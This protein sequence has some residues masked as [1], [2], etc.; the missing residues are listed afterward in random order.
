M[1]REEARTAVREER[2][3][4]FAAWISKACRSWRKHDMRSFW[5][6]IRNTAGYKLRREAA[7]GI[8]DPESNEVVT[9][10]TRTASIWANYFGGLA[11]DH[12]GHSKDP[13]YWSTRLVDRTETLDENSRPL[14]WSECAEVIKALA[15]GKASGLDGMPA[16]WFKVCLVGG[17]GAD[18]TPVSPMAKALWKL[19][20][21][22]WNS[23]TV[24]DSWNEASVVPVP[25]KGDLTRTDNYRGIALMQV[26]MKI[27][28]TVIA[29]RLQRLAE[30]HGLLTHA[31]AGFRS[32][33]EAVGQVAALYEIARRREIEGERTLVMFVDFAKAY[34][35]VPHAALLKKLSAMGIRGKLLRLLTAMYKAPRLS[36]KT[37]S[38]S[39]SESTPLEIGVRQGCPSSPILF[40]LF[41][42]DLVDEIE[43]GEMGVDIPAIGDPK[44]GALLFADDLVMMA[45]S[46]EQLGT[47]VGRL[48]RWCQR[49]EMKVNASKCGVMQIGVDSAADDLIVQ[50]GED[51]VPVVKAYTY[52][53]CHF[54][55][56]LDIEAMARHRAKIGSASLEELRPFIANGTIP[57]WVRRHVLTSIILPRMLYGAE[58]WGMNGGRSEPAQRV[59]DKSTRLLLSISGIGAGLSLNAMREELGI[60]RV[61]ALAAARRARAIIKFGTLKT[62]IA[63][64]V[65][66]PLTVQKSTWVSGTT[67]WINRY[68]NVPPLQ[69]TRVEDPTGQSIQ[70]RV[71]R[72]LM[73]KEAQKDSTKTMRWRAQMRLQSAEEAGIVQLM[74]RH[75]HLAKG[76]GQLMKLRCKAIRFAPWLAQMEFILPEFRDKCPMCLERVKEDE[77]HIL[78]SCTSY[79][80]ERER[81]LAIWIRRASLCAADP[82]GI[83]SLLLG[84][85][86]DGRQLD[87]WSSSPGD[88]GRQV[89]ELAEED[90]HWGTLSSGGPD[91]EVVDL[92][93]ESGRY[94]CLDVARFMME[95]SRLRVQRL[96]TVSLQT[97]PPRVEARQGMT[98][99]VRTAANQVRHNRAVAIQNVEG[100]VSERLTLPEQSGAYSAQGSLPRVQELEQSGELGVESDPEMDT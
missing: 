95:V 58:L 88:N 5:Q 35:S 9:D 44:I 1:A 32:R 33:E 82:G 14:Q 85:E 64:L 16:E 17:Q 100:L 20:T 86:R 10:P 46:Q 4:L 94:A 87:G 53:G 12:S 98:A 84:G 8:V 48:E 70:R 61:E 59:A 38:G 26:G 54:T 29:R 6:W 13:E 25:K 50:I 78:L 41:I 2:K 3:R 49:W 15:R 23:E 91:M 96:A 73:D 21:S 83:V 24:P 45:E 62:W 63:E 75:Q 65:K 93:G 60:G 7:L 39:Q 72:T 18:L 66:N 42:N 74:M 36:V 28:S 80:V 11:K 92:V 51:R 37:P 57:I 89:R 22:I 79:S 27:I 52:L 56:D 71:Y 31:Q 69:K 76:L 43:A 67:R 90:R 40:N 34:D 81:F 47:M 55:H 19:L 68:T 30:R 97:M 99:L 77:V